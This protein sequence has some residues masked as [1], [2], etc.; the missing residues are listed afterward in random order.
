MSMAGD[1]ATLPEHDAGAGLVQ[2]GAERVGAAVGAGH[3][4]FGLLIRGQHADGHRAGS[5]RRA[6]VIGGVAD[7]CGGTN[8]GGE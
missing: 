1:H 5:Q 8:A 3:E 7:L 4:G 2:R 6:H